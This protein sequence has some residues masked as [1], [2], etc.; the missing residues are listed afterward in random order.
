MFNEIK[1]LLRRL[2]GR[3][4]RSPKKI[5]RAH[6]EQTIEQSPPEVETTPAQEI[7]YDG[8]V[9]DIRNAD[10]MGDYLR[11]L[12][13]LRGFEK[14]TRNLSLNWLRVRLD[15]VGKTLESLSSQNDFEDEEFNFKLAKKVRDVAG[16]MLDIYRD[17]KLSSKLDETS[18]Q[19]LRDLVED[20]LSA[21]GLTQKIF[22]PGDSYDDWTN[23]EM[24]ESCQII[25]TDNREEHSTIAEVEIQPHI[26]SYRGDG[27]EVEQLI[28][29]GSCRAYRFK[30][31]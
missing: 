28:F 21:I 20:Y 14:F 8:F 11:K 31:D 10:D 6:R 3:D 13:D 15:R 9:L 1:K 7:H 5:I 18:R 17:A 12:N 23:L 27:G 22:K 19:E 30:E 29:G 2:R 4:K 26:I 16:V 24:K 25:H